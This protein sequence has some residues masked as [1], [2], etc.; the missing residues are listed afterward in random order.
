MLNLGSPNPPVEIEPLGL[1]ICWSVVSA[2]INSSIRPR[3]LSSSPRVYLEM[4][5]WFGGS[6]RV[7]GNALVNDGLEHQR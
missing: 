7:S 4:A 1:V 5:E 6:T 3:R 2:C